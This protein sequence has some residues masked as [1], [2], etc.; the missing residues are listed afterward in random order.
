MVAT[1]F[2]EQGYPITVVLK[3]LGL[4][5]SSYYYKPRSSQAKRGRR[6]SGYTMTL[7]GKTVSNDQVVEDIIDLLGHEFVDYGYRKVT[8]HLQQE[9]GYVINRKKVYRL[10]SEKGLLNSPRKP[11]SSTKNWV[12]ALLPATQGCFSYLEFD[13]KYVWVNA[14]R[15]NIMVLTAIDVESRWVLGQTMGKGI[16]KHDVSELFEQIFAYYPLP[17][18]VWVRNDNGSQMISEHVR[19]FFAENDVVQEFTKPAT[20][21]QNA[22]IE[23]YHSIVERVICQRFEFESMPDAYATFERWIGFYNHKRIHS[24]I[25]YLSP[26]KHLVKHGYQPNLLPLIHIPKS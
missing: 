12:Q 16:S 23:S 3:Q 1:Q 6:A 4:S 7:S 9:V 19:S 11:R 22:H 20:P 24:G 14:E 2:I 18:Q 25:K 17:K 13:I 21:E 10:M 15:T 26:A 8:C 5:R